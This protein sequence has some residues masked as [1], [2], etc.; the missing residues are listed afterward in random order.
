MANKLAISTGN[1][2]TGGT[3]VT[4]NTGTNAVLISTSSAKRPRDFRGATMTRGMLTEAEA[5]ARAEAFMERLERILRK[6]PQTM[7]DEIDNDLRAQARAACEKFKWCSLWP[8]N[9]RREH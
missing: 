9:S 5:N 6:N 2:T 4:G 1:F 3:W 7:D 8:S